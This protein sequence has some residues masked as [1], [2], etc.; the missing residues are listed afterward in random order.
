MDRAC[1]GFR[2]VFIEAER[3]AV[4]MHSVRRAGVGAKVAWCAPLYLPRL[5]GEGEDEA[6]VTGEA[7]SLEECGF[8]PLTQKVDMAMGGTLPALAVSHF[9]HHPRSPSKAVVTLWWFC[10]V[11]AEP[12]TLRGKDRSGAGRTG[13]TLPFPPGQV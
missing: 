9:F 5:V 3:F 4:R 11:T 12:V 7:G 10:G 8:F 1:R 6:R 13:V 2:G